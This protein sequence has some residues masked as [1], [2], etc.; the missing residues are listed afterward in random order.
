MH[1]GI[2]VPYEVVLV[3]GGAALGFLPIREALLP[4]PEL[5][6]FIFIPPLLFQGAWTFDAREFLERWQPITLLALAGTVITAALVSAG[7]HRLWHASW[8]TSLL[9]GAIVSATD[10]IA[11]LAVFRRLG[12]PA[13]LAA[14]IEGESLLNDGVAVVLFRVFVATAV[15]GTLIAPLAA[16]WMFTAVTLVGVACGAAVGILTIF[17]L[18][19]ARHPAV[20][21]V[22]TLFVAYGSYALA[23][24]VHGSGIFAVLA[25]ALLMNAREHR[26]SSRR[27]VT[28]SWD[29][30]AFVANAVL[31]VVVGLQIDRG[32]VAGAAV[33]VALAVLATYVARSIAVLALIPVL[34]RHRRP[35]RR[36]R[37]V[38][39]WG[40]LRGAISMA[41][42]LSLPLT[43][44]GRGLIVAATAGV[45][46]VTLV[47]GGVTMQPLLARLGLTARAT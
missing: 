17:V 26:V 12:A 38:L 8:E 41:L 16:A 9:F 3:V 39:I 42:A 27:A 1:R 35:P 10:P 21:L 7:V 44:A 31:W 36:W 2:V 46:F 23:E 29:R 5:V 6:L 40:G 22:L 4:A 34:P 20:E 13:G 32:L 45:V 15:G 33:P 25:A 14:I 24:R 18:R 28:F 30:I 11:V 47:L 43:I 37:L 19:L